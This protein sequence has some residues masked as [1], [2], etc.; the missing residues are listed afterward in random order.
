MRSWARLCLLAVLMLSSAVVPPPAGR[1]SGATPTTAHFVIAAEATAGA[2]D[3]AATTTLYRAAGPRGLSTLQRTDQFTPSTSG[4]D[5]LGFYPT[6][7][8]ASNYARLGYRSGLDAFKGPYTMVS[9]DVPT[10]MLEKFIPTYISGEGNAF[11][12]PNELLPALGKPTV[13]DSMV[14]PR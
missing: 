10:S 6:A 9:T 1:A 11:L 5:Y 14:V 12:V 8:Q 2:G 7:E 4:A 3:T 13:W